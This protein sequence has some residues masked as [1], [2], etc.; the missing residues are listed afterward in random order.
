MAGSGLFLMPQSILFQETVPGSEQPHISHGNELARL[1]RVGATLV[2]SAYL[3]LA[4]RASLELTLM[5]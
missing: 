5:R 1:G 2:A 4:Y 3:S